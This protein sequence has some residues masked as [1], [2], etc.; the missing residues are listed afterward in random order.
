MTMAYCQAD[1]EQISEAIVN[2]D[3]ALK[4]DETEEFSASLNYLKKCL[5]LRSNLYETPDTKIE[6]A[7]QIIERL[8]NTNNLSSN[9]I[10]K[11]LKHMNVFNDT[12]EVTDCEDSCYNTMLR[13]LIVHISK[14]I[15][16]NIF[17]EVFQLETVLFNDTATSFKQIWI[18][19]NDAIKTYSEAIHENIEFEINEKLLMWFDLIKLAKKYQMWDL[20]STLCRLCLLF[21]D[22]SYWSVLLK[23]L[24][25]YRITRTKPIVG[26]STAMKPMEINPNT[27]MPTKTDVQNLLNKPKPNQRG[28]INP[29]DIITTFELKLY[30]SLSEIC[31]IYGECLS[32]LLRQQSCGIQLAGNLD[33]LRP[34]WFDVTSLV[35]SD[36]EEVPEKLKEHNLQWKSY[37]E[38]FLLVNESAL[39]AF[40]R[41][42]VLS[43][44]IVDSNTLYSCAVCVW[45][46]CLPTICQNDHCQLTTIFSIILENANKIGANCLPA[47]L[48]AEMATVLAHGLIQ[49]WLPKPVKSG[50]LSGG[51]KT[52]TIP[53]NAPQKGQKVNRGKS[54]KP[55]IYTV[56]PEG[57]A[58][59]KKAIDWLMLAG[60]L[61][62]PNRLDLLQEIDEGS[63]IQP[64]LSLSTRSRLII[65]WLS[66]KQ[67]ITN[68]P[69]HRNLFP[70][71]SSEDNS[72]YTEIN[73]T[74]D[75]D[76]QTRKRATNN[77][78]DA[79]IYLETLITRT[80][81]AVHSLWLTN[82][83]KY[84]SE[85]CV[86]LSRLI[87]EQSTQTIIE[88]T[89]Q[90]DILVGFK[91]APTLAE[92]I[93][94]M[95]TT[96]SSQK[97]NIHTE[98]PSGRI[99]I[100]NEQEKTIVKYDLRLNQSAT[101]RFTEL[102]L[103]TRLAM[104]AFITSQYST[105][106]DII[107]M[108]NIQKELHH[109]DNKQHI[110][111]NNNYWLVHLLCLRGL[112][113]FGISNQMKTIRQ[114][115]L[116]SGGKHVQQQSQ[117]QQQQQTRGKQ[118]FTDV[119][120]KY[121][122]LLERRPDKSEISEDSQTIENSLFEAGEEAFY[123]ASH[124]SPYPTMTQFEMDLQLRVNMYTA[125]YDLYS[126]Q[127]NFNEALTVLDKATQNLPRTKHRMS[128]FRQLVITKAKLGQSVHLDMQKFTSESE[129]LQSQIWREIA[130]A[131]SNVHVQVTAFKQSIDAIKNSAQWAL[132]SD[133]LLELAQWLFAHG[134]EVPLCIS[135]VEEAMDLLKDAYV[136]QNYPSQCK[137][138]KYDQLICNAKYVEYLD[139]LM[140][141]CILLAEFGEAINPNLKKEY[142]FNPLDYLIIAVNCVESILNL[143][144]ASVVQSPRVE[145]KSPR[146][147]RSTSV[148]SRS[149]SNA[150]VG[151]EGYRGKQGS[152]RVHKKI[153]PQTV[154]DWSTYEVSDDII[155]AW[156]K[157]YTDYI[158]KS[159]NVNSSNLEHEDYS[160]FID[161]YLVK[162]QINPKTIRYPT[163]TMACLDRLLD[164]ITEMGPA[165][166]GFPILVLQDCICEVGQDTI[167]YLCLRIV[168]VSEN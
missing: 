161:V 96:F 151:N 145:P 36:G 70:M 47:Q 33:H 75:S 117:Q 125:L 43:A 38:W 127:G 108:S 100:P 24:E 30:S 82:K 81:L 159:V 58:Y 132:K 158:N 140:R 76:N 124:Q 67:L 143:S 90:M 57:Q 3:K 146:S 84:I 168:P 83:S 39:L 53:S 157:N 40:Q 6:Q 35:D 119:K 166:L 12:K 52:K 23:K 130:Y 136:K 137:E 68:P 98:L 1:M 41:S 4:F 51:D 102:E 29:Q 94:L 164:L 86:I 149:K 15:D 153:L 111:V 22:D 162:Q 160:G 150:P 42:A 122:E 11:L 77:Q 101:D 19:V 49:P 147:P 17:E 8:Q 44:R 126:E 69:V 2:I 28:T 95:Q 89:K 134:F 99:N 88:P 107:D 55:T 46:Y 105:I 93:H 139:I 103:W 54:A 115:N 165:Q 152:E 34:S 106:L 20:C 74:S 120:F 25:Q 21:D 63:T 167:N 10:T 9:E 109:G 144:V 27:Q 129:P 141:I 131:S 121:V 66:A 60:K 112:A 56:P 59:I 114:Q 72:I 104:L 135:L 7:R 142:N 97:P 62:E 116:K 155:Q 85:W 92:A 91:D 113:M 71:D 26:P 110:D 148:K 123:K 5:L 45:N 87:D 156:H 65:C 61:C 154:S 13:T 80:L 64:I 48:Y 138:L 128:L 32:I 18:Q 163:V 118:R 31:C 78:K 73:S 79:Q 37:C 14:L 16:E 50:T 133:L